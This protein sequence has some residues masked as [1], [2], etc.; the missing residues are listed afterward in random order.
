MA[1]ERLYR[2]NYGQIFGVCKGL[3]QW[4]DLPVRSV[5]LVFILLASFTC[6]FPCLVAYF[7]LALVLKANPHERPSGPD[8]NG[9]CNNYHKGRRGK[10]RG[11]WAFSDDYETVDEDEMRRQYEDLKRKVDEMEDSARNKDKERDWD[12]RFDSEDGKTR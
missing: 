7:L 3:A 6:V 10:G 11:D 1:T 9:D 2:S 5:R 12:R 8:E 4:R